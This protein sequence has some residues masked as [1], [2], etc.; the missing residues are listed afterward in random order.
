MVEQK[1]PVGINSIHRAL[2]MMEIMAHRQRPLGVSE[3]GRIMGLDPATVYRI[4]ATLTAAGWV[5]RN[6]DNHRYS[7]SLKLTYLGASVNQHDLL[8]QQAQASLKRLAQE[9]GETAHLAVLDGGEVV[10][11]A[12]EMGSHFL[13][14][15]VDLLSR[16][17]SYCTAVGK[18]ILGALS[19]FQVEMRLSGVTFER[20]TPNTIVSL[21]D[22]Q[23]HLRR[24]R[25]QGYAVDDEEYSVGVRCVAAP[26]FQEGQPIASIGLTGPAVRVTGERTV[27]LA[28]AVLASAREMTV[29]LTDAEA[30]RADAEGSHDA[31]ASVVAA[32]KEEGGL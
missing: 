7:L 32:A 25:A 15:N 9:S 17:P 30:R 21:P 20:R 2:T 13:A 29:L 14:V 10:F 3:L 22:L 19:P 26:I 4:L 11:L 1:R 24:V 31:A 23:A 28:D 27:Q 8:R 18:A 5:Q 12:H 6:E 16:G